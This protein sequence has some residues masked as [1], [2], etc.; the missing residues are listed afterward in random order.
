MLRQK[1]ETNGEIVYDYEVIFHQEITQWNA[2]NT[3]DFPIYPYTR[4]G[5]LITKMIIQPVHTDYSEDYAYQVL[6]DYIDEITIKFDSVQVEQMDKRL[7]EH[8]INTGL[9]KGMSKNFLVE[10]SIITYYFCNYKEKN[11]KKGQ[12]VS[13]STL[14]HYKTKRDGAPGFVIKLN[15]YLFGVKQFSL[16]R[17]GFIDKNQLSY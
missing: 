13:Q 7:F 5:E 9:D 14:I 10:N 4:I 17:F 16:W 3:V 11:F 1:I 15:T 12:S 2:V 8:V 6:N